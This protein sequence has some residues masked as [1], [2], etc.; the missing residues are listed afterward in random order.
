[1]K[2]VSVPSWR[3]SERK[4]DLEV[5]AQVEVLGDDLLVVLWGGTRPHIGAI[6]VAQPRPSLLDPKD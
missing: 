5:F 4:G 6:G 2:S 1:M 3:I